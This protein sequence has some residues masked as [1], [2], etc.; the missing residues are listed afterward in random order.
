MNRSIPDQDRWINLI[1]PAHIKLIAG[2]GDARQYIFHNPINPQ[3]L[4]LTSAGY[5][6][7]KN[8]LEVIIYDFDLRRP[9]T[10]KMLLQLE[11]Y[12]QYP[13]FV[14][15]KKKVIAFDEATAIMLELHGGDLET[16]LNN[17]EQHQ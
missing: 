16:Y 12:M 17:L 15:N 4:R 7:F 6:Y 13:Y 2:A 10:P 14:F 5:Y 11:K 8:V 9:L 3:S 1:D